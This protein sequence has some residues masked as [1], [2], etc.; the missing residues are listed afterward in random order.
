MSPIAAGRDG[1]RR[2]VAPG[3]EGV[4]SVAIVDARVLGAG[5]ANGHHGPSPLNHL[6]GRRGGIEHSSTFTGPITAC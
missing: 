5:T 2:S 3:S 4:V 6:G 1:V